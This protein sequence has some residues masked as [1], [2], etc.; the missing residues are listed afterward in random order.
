MIITNIYKK[1]GWEGNLQQLSAFNCQIGNLN[2]KKPYLNS[3][4]S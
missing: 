1:K 3:L 4:K 2:V